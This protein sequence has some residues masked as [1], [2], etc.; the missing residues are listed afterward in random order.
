MYSLDVERVSPLER[1][2]LV[3]LL[4]PELRDEVDLVLERQEVQHSLLPRN[5]LH[6]HIVDLQDL[7]PGLETLRRSRTARLDGGNEDTDFIAARESNP[8]A[9]RLLKADESR[10]RAGGGKTTVQ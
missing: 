8:D 4:F 9:A 5:A 10:I 2:N 1:H 3:V 7:V 6:V